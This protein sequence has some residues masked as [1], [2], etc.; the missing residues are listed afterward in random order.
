M[1]FARG[2]GQDKMNADM[3]VSR[4]NSTKAKVSAS[5]RAVPNGTCVHSGLRR[6]PRLVASAFCVAI[7]MLSG[8]SHQDF[9]GP[10]TSPITDVVDS[11]KPY[12]QNQ[13]R[14]EALL[15]AHRLAKVLAEWKGETVQGST[16][17]ALGADDVLELSILNLEEPGKE[18]KLVRTIAKDGSINIP[19]A[20]KVSVAGGNAQDAEKKVADA[21]AERIIKNPQV[22]VVVSVFKS[23]PVL[24]TGAV[25]KPGVYCLKKNRSTLLE[26]LAQADGL[27]NDSG[28]EMLIIRGGTLTDSNAVEKAVTQTDS[29]ATPNLISIDLKQLLDA[30]D[31]RLNLWVKSGDIITVLPKSRNYVYVLGYVQRPGSV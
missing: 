14:S 24:V 29:N 13:G 12:V 18:S 21:L 2:D 5:F 7:A 15:R 22:T 4:D 23:A 17:Y 1:L 27:S 16:D 19:W 28:D 11:G 20:G 9:G 30:G 6:L 31:L 10:I 8:C 25:T 3:V 26:I